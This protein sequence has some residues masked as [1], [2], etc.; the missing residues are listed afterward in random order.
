MCTNQLGESGK[1]KAEENEAKSKEKIGESNPGTKFY[2]SLCT[3]MDNMMEK[4]D[5]RFG[6]LNRNLKGEKDPA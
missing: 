3:I 4:F 6:E 2:E 5:A 1:E